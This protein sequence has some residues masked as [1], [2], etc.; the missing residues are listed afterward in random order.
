MLKRAFLSKGRDIK[1][2]TGGFRKKIHGFGP[3]SMFLFELTK[4]TAKKKVSIK[5]YCK[6]KYNIAIQYPDL[7]C[8]D[9]GKGSYLP[10]ELCR[11]ELKNKKK[12]TEKE[13]ADMIKQ[14]AVKAT[15]R[16]NYIQNWITSSSIEKDPVLKEYNIKIDLKAIELT[17]RV[18]EAPDIQ[19]GGGPKPFLAMSR[20]IAEKGQWDHRN[21]KL[22]NGKTISKWIVLNF[23]G[24]V[25]QDVA[26]DFAMELVRIGK[27]HGVTMANPL[28]YAEKVGRGGQ[29]SNEDARRLFENMVTK[30]Q[31][32]NQ[33]LQL[34]YRKKS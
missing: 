34:E 32:I 6:E 23:S 27:I 11:T 31:G 25:K 18:L 20:S 26:Y 10:M 16:L 9:L 21:F 3:D 14:T 17:G 7:P 19:Y 2:E 24:R 15:E 12:L 5:D 4:G 33:N 29:V 8:I 22:L 30:H 28:D 13:T 1:T